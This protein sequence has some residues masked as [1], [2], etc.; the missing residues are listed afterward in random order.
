M[1]YKHPRATPRAYNC[2]S[3][4]SDGI[5]S[6][7][8]VW[9]VLRPWYK[10]SHKNMSSH[11]KILQNNHTKN[12]NCFDNLLNI[13]AFF[14]VF[15][16]YVYKWANFKFKSLGQKSS[17]FFFFFFAGVK[18]VAEDDLGSSMLPCYQHP[19]FWKITAIVL[20][21]IWNYYNQFIRCEVPELGCLWLRKSQ[22]LNSPAK[23]NIACVF[24][25]KTL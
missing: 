8:N 7:M 6:R 13:S 3:G 12:S 14:T 9:L 24:L 25:L 21:V 20:K 1:A 18:G 17:T 22:K 10:S 4:N 23:E 5:K 16:L 19:P 15:F 11:P 2:R